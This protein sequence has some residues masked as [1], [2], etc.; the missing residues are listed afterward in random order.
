M[1]TIFIALALLVFSYTNLVLEPVEETGKKPQKIYTTPW[2][3]E[4]RDVVG[5]NWS[6]VAVSKIPVVKICLFKTVTSHR[7]FARNDMLGEESKLQ[8]A[9]NVTARWDNENG[10]SLASH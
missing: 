10:V 8:D 4:Y 7:Q 3:S 5:G 2:F 1:F 9:I 6:I